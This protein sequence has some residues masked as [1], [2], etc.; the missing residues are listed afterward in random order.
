MALDAKKVL[1]I[2]NQYTDDSMQ[3]AGAV[4]GKPCQIQSITDI[5]GGHRITFL[6]VDNSGTEHTST[7]D[8]MDGQQGAQ[9]ETGATGRGIAS[10]SVDANDHLIITYDDGTTEDAGQIEITAAVDSVNGKTGEVTLDASDV[11]AYS[12]SEVDTA[13]A[14]KVDKVN[15]AVFIHIG[16]VPVKN[17][18]CG[19]KLTL[20][21]SKVT[22]L[23]SAVIIGITRNEIIFLKAPVIGKA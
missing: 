12:T 2:A 3:G 9:G 5:T 1:A 4:A 18:F 22:C 23:C 17:I 20:Y 8:V 19:D 16:A 10:V 7:M 6:W 14:D 13:L 11:G 21:D 15:S